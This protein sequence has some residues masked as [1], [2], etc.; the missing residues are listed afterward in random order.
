MCINVVDIVWYGDDLLMFF[1]LLMVG[2]VLLKVE[3]VKILFFIVCWL[4]FGCG[5]I[6]LIE[7]V[8][9]LVVMCEIVVVLGV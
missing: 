5:L 9:G 4:G 2:I 8:V 1:V 6:V 3:E 7:S